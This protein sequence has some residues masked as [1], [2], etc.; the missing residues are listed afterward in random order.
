MLFHRISRGAPV[1]RIT[2]ET[3]GLIGFGLIMIA[4][5]PFSVWPGGALQEFTGSYLKALLVFIL[6]VNTLTTPKRLEQLTWLILVSRRVRRRARA[7]S[8]TRGASISSRAGVLR[9]PSAASSATRTTS[10]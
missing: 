7:C 5:V 8:T 2:P 3:V 9:A 4:T 1:F 10:R 6:M